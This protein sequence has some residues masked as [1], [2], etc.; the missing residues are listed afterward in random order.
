MTSSEML[1][2]IDGEVHVR[3]PLKSLAR[4]AASS[5][6]VI[7]AKCDRIDS[8]GEGVLNDVA[9]TRNQSQRFRE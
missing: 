1:G 9:E 8:F 6:I 4:S 7:A 5:G 2:S 3:S